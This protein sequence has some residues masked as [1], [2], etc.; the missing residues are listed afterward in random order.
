MLKYMVDYN[1]CN[2]HKNKKKSVYH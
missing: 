2:L 1:T